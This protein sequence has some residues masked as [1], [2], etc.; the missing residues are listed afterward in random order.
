MEPGVEPLRVAQAREVAPSPDVCI[1]DRVTR[2]FGVAQDEAGD[3]FEARDGRVDEPCEGVMI[4][5]SRS[6]DEIRW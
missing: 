2:E 3:R 6:F 4:A 5:P 1:L